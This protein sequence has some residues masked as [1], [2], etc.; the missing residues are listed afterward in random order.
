MTIFD[1]QLNLNESVLRTTVVRDEGGSAP[2]DT[3]PLDRLDPISEGSGP[4]H[5]VPAAEHSH[6]HP[7]RFAE[8]MSRVDGCGECVSNYA[9]PS[10]V[11]DD[12]DGGFLANYICESCGHA[13]TTSWRDA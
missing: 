6:T 8:R 4:V 5:I 3:R 12:N 13:W 7:P 10:A 11:Y 1:R 9:T 2:T